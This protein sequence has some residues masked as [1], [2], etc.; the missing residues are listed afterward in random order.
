MFRKELE[1]FIATRT[2]PF[3]NIILDVV[4]GDLEKAMEKA[5]KYEI[6]DY[7]FEVS[8]RAAPDRRNAGFQS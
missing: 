8:L 4:H 7:K 1:T 5:L 2:V 6:H 3:N